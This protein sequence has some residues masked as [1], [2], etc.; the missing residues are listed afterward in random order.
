MN[1][2]ASLMHVPLSKNSRQRQRCFFPYSFKNQDYEMMLLSEAN[3]FE[4]SAV[5]SLS[6]YCGDCETTVGKWVETACMSD[7]LL[8]GPMLIK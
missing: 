7:C 1:L 5:P 4:Y 6:S 3:L 2:A 8:F